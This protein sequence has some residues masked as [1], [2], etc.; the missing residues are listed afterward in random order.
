MSMHFKAAAL[1]AGVL[2]TVATGAAAA[3]AKGKALSVDGVWKVTHVEITGA[4]PLTVASPLANLTIFSHGHYASVGDQGQKPRMAAAAYK[5]P[6]KPTDAEKLAKYEEWAPL[7]AQAGTYSLKGATLTRTPV[8]AKNV[9]QVT[10]GGFTSD[11]KLT[12]DTLVL[13]TKSP[14]GQPAREQTVTYTRVK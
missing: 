14:A 6:G 5:E 4:N 2:L 10:A 13:V 7:G 3:E 1:A 11:V 8:V 9:G 12:G